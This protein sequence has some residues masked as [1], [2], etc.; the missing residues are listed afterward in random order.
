VYGLRCLWAV[1]GFRGITPSALLKVSKSVRIR[2]CM[3]VTLPVILYG[4][5]IW[6]LTIRKEIR[7]SVLENRVRRI[8]ESK[9]DDGEENCIMR[10]FITCTLRQV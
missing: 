5:E 6:S 3:T 8:F 9:R 2:I 1:S 4:Y 7:L 10:S